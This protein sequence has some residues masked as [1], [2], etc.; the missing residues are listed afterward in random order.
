[1][2]RCCDRI[3]DRD[4]FQLVE[5]LSFAFGETEMI[6]SILAIKPIKEFGRYERQSNARKSRSNF[7]L[8]RSLIWSLIALV[9]GCFSIVSHAGEYNQVLSIGDQSP[10]WIGLPGIDGMN[11]DFKDWDKHPLV[12]VV[13]TCNSCPYAVDAEDRLISLH[14]KY[15]SRSVAVVAINVN[16]IEEDRLPAMKVRA[17]KK[18][19]PF[20]Y[21]F[22]ESQKIARNFGAMAT[23]E[24]FLLDQQRKVRYMG[25]IDDSPDGKQITK[26]YL[27]D[28]IE[29][30]LEGKDPV[31]PE[32]VPIGCRV[33]FERVRRS[34]P[35]PK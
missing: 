24:C 27:E 33:R 3:R 28:A 5:P 35:A 11:H 2:H 25:S 16:T 23:P 15:A 1:M 26:R 12:V 20:T 9:I 32:T 34:R 8:G 18:G 22:D 6:H 10:T 17:E 13:F 19:F 31:Q 21:L 29:S 4:D 7:I 14:K 30:V